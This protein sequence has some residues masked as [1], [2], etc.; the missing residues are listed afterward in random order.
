M[1]TGDE[2]PH[3]II[4]RRI[5]AIMKKLDKSKLESS[6]FS[7]I[8]SMSSSITKSMSASSIEKQHINPDDRRI[9]SPGRLSAVT[10][11]TNQSI[12]TAII[13][14]LDV[15][16]KNH[17]KKLKHLAKLLYTQ[18]YFKEYKVSYIY[19]ILVWIALRILID[20]KKATLKGYDE[21]MENVYQETNSVNTNKDLIINFL[22]DKKPFYRIINYDQLLY[23]FS[24][25]AGVLRLQ[26]VKKTKNKTAEDI[27]QMV[28]NQ[29]N[30]THSKTVSFLTVLSSY[31]LNSKLMDRRIYNKIQKAIDK[32]KAKDHKKINI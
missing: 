22:A 14:I 20:S 8:K 11:Q 17:I 13:E 32:L 7:N 27:D 4:A 18:E 6:S 2:E 31:L 15:N 10:G 9:T 23:L 12:K 16:S 28:I 19:Q 29:T 26:A 24:S 5:R 1:D 21:Y 3:Q 30:I 25:Y